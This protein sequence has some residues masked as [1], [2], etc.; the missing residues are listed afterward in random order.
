MYHYNPHWGDFASRCGC[1]V[2]QT[3]ASCGTIP[4]HRVMQNHDPIDISVVVPMYNEAELIVENMRVILSVLEEH[5]IQY[6]IVA[7]DDGSIDDTYA[8]VAEAFSTVPALR[9]LRHEH[10]KG[11][12]P[13]VRTGLA[14]ARGRYIT[15]LDAD[16]QFDPHDVIRFYR[17]AQ[18]QSVPVVWGNSDKS[19]YS[20]LRKVVSN[21]HNIVAQVLFGVPANLDINSIQL[22]ERSTLDSFHYSDKKEAIG[23]ELLLHSV[24]NGHRIESMPVMVSERTQGYSKFHWRLIF[25]SLRSMLSL[26]SHRIRG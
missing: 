11:Y 16:L 26:L 15:V 7:V 12:S 24:K 10:N 17:Y 5:G 14:A 2:R 23:L 3:T 9:L 21:S 8:R 13:A 19:T 20:L 6:E 4:I 18:S 1:V 25:Q 22:I